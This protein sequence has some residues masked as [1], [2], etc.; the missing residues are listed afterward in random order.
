MAASL[1]VKGNQPTSG[2]GRAKHIRK[3]I[4]FLNSTIIPDVDDTVVDKLVYHER[5]GTSARTLSTNVVQPSRR[6]DVHS[7]PSYPVAGAT[8]V[9]RTGS[10]GRYNLALGHLA[11]KGELVHCLKLAAQMKVQGVKPD[12]LTF[13]C[14]IRACERDAL[15]RHATAIF[16]DM[17]AVGL[18]P[19][20][21]TYHLL[22]KVFVFRSAS[23]FGCFLTL[24]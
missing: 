23:V 20:R 10:I 4:A 17:L 7:F 11:D 14:L 24:E 18:Q 15:S 13:N 19:E 9:S 12:I 2:L 1:S 8:T 22:F 6:F 16:E 3:Y 21:E 5:R